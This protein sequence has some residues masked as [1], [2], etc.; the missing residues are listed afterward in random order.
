M[1]SHADAQRKARQCEH[2]SEG[3]TRQH[4]TDRERKSAPLLAP[5]LL[6]FTG[7]TVVKANEAA[8]E[9]PHSGAANESLQRKISRSLD[10]AKERARTVCRELGAREREST[11]QVLMARDNTFLY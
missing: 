6:P 7:A 10:E 2:K 1:S 4:H 9:T 11:P 3:S 5:R 8:I